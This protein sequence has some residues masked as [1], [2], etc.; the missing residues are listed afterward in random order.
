MVAWVINMPLLL[1]ENS[2]NLLFLQSSLSFKTIRT[3]ISLK[4]FTC[5]KFFKQ[6]VKHLTLNHLNLLNTIPLT[7]TKTS[8]NN[9]LMSFKRS[10]YNISYPFSK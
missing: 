10:T 8:I 7:R 9:L 3:F 2:S 1:L 4:Y 5:F 6:A